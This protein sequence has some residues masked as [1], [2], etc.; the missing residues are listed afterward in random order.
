MF[1]PEDFTKVKPTGPVLT[2]LE[3]SGPVHVYVHILSLPTDPYVLG[4]ATWT[5]SSDY[6]MFNK[7]FRTTSLSAIF[8]ENTPLQQV[9]TT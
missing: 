8:H 9:H 7:Q 5:F 1:C 3:L 4:F 6:T 2:Y